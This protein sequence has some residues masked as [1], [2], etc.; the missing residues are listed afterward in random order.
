MTV[1]PRPP[2]GASPPTLP[3]RDSE[4][5]IAQPGTSRRSTKARMSLP[6]LFEPALDLLVGGPPDVE[7]EVE[8]EAEE[9]AGAGHLVLGV[10]VDDAEPEVGAQLV[11]GVEPGDTD[12]ERHVRHRSS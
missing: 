3:W 11:E 7:R 12:P 8:L 5:E 6:L 10:L 1:V 4:V 9:I 2:P